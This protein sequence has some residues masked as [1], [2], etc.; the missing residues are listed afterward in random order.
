MCLR[1]V[2]LLQDLDMES[3][4]RHGARRSLKIFLDGN[5]RESGEADSPCFDFRFFWIVIEWTSA[6]QCMPVT[7]RSF[8]SMSNAKPQIIAQDATPRGSTLLSLSQ[9]QSDSA[10]LRGKRCLFVACRCGDT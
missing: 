4:R 6:N 1:S 2:F 5:D 3:C 10:W 8:S 9:S 7:E